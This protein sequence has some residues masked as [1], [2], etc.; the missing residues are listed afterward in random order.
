MKK[1]LIFLSLIALNSCTSPMNEATKNAATHNAQERLNSS[2][3]G[4]NSITKE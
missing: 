2:Q 3:N 1:I 4:A